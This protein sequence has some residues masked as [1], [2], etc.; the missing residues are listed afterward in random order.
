MILCRQQRNVINK[1]PWSTAL[2]RS[3]ITLK[4]CSQHMNKIKVEFTVWTNTSLISMSGLTIILPLVLWHCWL[5]VRE[6]LACKNWVMRCWCG[7]L[8]GARCRLFG[9]GPADATASQNPIISCL[10]QIQTGFTF[11]YQLTQVV[12]EKRPLNGCSSSS[13]SPVWMATLEYVSLL[14]T[15]RALTIWDE[16]QPINMK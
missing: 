11:L 5:G 6:H 10:M 1:Q 4:R 7:Y 2:S 8:P 9:Y 15:K 16:L 14:R 12:L 3:S 13:S